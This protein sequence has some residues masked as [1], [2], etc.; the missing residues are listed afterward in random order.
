M[1][2]ALFGDEG[3]AVDLMAPDDDVVRRKLERVLWRAKKWWLEREGEAWADDEYEALQHQ[4]MQQVLDRRHRHLQPET[5]P[6]SWRTW[7]AP[8]W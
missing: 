2:K 6:C 3:Q 5:S 4:A 8:R 7:L 1:P